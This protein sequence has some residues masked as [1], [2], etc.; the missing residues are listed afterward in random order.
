MMFA[1]VQNMP[2]SIRVQID[3]TLE[4]AKIFCAKNGIEFFG[5]IEVGTPVEKTIEYSQ[6]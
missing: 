2:E 6:R 5:E 1:V 4:E 3:K